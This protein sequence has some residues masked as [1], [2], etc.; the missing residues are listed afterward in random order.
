MSSASAHTNPYETPSS[1]LLQ[2]KG[3]LERRRVVKLYFGL[4][5]GAV[6][7]RGAAALSLESVRPLELAGVAALAGALPA[8]FGYACRRPVGRAG[9]WKLWLP[10]AIAGAA[11]AG[12]TSMPLRLEPELW[13]AAQLYAR[14]FDA[15]LCAALYLYAFRSPEM[16]RQS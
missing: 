13:R 9:L 12:M 3:M 15:P 11:S 7:A 16:W 4:A 2:I 8:L 10:I 6:L 5:V 1:A 14:L